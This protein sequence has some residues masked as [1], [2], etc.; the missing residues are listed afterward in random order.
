MRQN[1]FFIRQVMSFLLMVVLIVTGVHYTPKSVK[2]AP[3]DEI[4]TDTYV[5]QTET[6]ADLKTLFDDTK[7]IGTG[8][9]P[10]KP[11]KMDQN[12]NI[13]ASGESDYNLTIKA[14]INDKISLSSTGI[15]VKD[16]QNSDVSAT[17][18]DNLYLVKESGEKLKVDYLKLIQNSSDGEINYEVKA[19]DKDDNQLYGL[20]YYLVID[21]GDNDVVANINIKSI[22]VTTKMKIDGTVENNVGDGTSSNTFSYMGTGKVG[23]KIDLKELTGFEEFYY[24]NELNNLTECTQVQIVKSGNQYVLQPLDAEGNAAAQSVWIAYDHFYSFDVTLKNIVNEHS[25]DNGDVYLW[26]GTEYYITENEPATGKTPD[27]TRSVINSSLTTVKTESVNVTGRLGDSFISSELGELLIYA[28]T[29][30]KRNANMNWIN[31]KNHPSDDGGVRYYQGYCIKDYLK[32]N[33][34]TDKINYFQIYKNNEGKIMLGGVL[35]NQKKCDLR[36][37]DLYTTRGSVVKQ[38]LKWGVDK[39][40]YHIQLRVPSNVMTEKDGKLYSGRFTLI[41]G[42]G[43]VSYKGEILNSNQKFTNS[44]PDASDQQESNSLENWTSNIPAFTKIENTGNFVVNPDLFDAEKM[45]ITITYKVWGTLTAEGSTDTIEYTQEKP[46]EV[47]ETLSGKKLMQSFY[48]CPNLRGYDI[49][50]DLTTA[51]KQDI[52]KTDD[53]T[54]KVSVTKIWDDASD[55]HKLRPGS[56]TVTLERS[57]DGTTWNTFDGNT[58]TITGDSTKSIWTKELTGIQTTF[59]DSDGNVTPYQFRIK[60]NSETGA[61]EYTAAYDGLVVTNKLELENETE[62]TVNKKWLDKNGNSL[63]ENIP[64]SIDYYIYQDGKYYAKGTLSQSNSWSQTL[65]KLPVYKTATDKYTYTCCEL[66]EKGEKLSDGEIIKIDGKNYE[67]KVVDSSNGKKLISIV[68]TYRPIRKV[69][70]TKKVEN[71][72]LEKY[73]FPDSEDTNSF[74][75]TLKITNGKTF[76]DA[77]SYNTEKIK[78]E[79]V[80]RYSFSLK[81]NEST[82]L[83]VL[84]G[85]TV[86]TEEKNRTEEY[87]VCEWSSNVGGSSKSAVAVSSVTKEILD[88]STM[89]TICADQSRNKFV[90]TFVNGEIIDDTEAPKGKAFVGNSLFYDEINNNIGRI[91]NSVFTEK[92]PFTI[93]MRIKQIKEKNNY[94]TI[95]AKGD[96]QIAA[97]IENE[98]KSL[99]VYVWNGTEWIDYVFT[100]PDNWIGH[101]HHLAITFNGTN[102]VAYCDGVEMNN[103]QKRDINRIQTSNTAYGIGYE[104]EHLGERDGVNEYADFRIYNRSLSQEEI[105]AQMNAYKDNNYAIDA[106][107]ENVVMWMDYSKVTTGNAFFKTINSDTELLCENQ[108]TYYGDVEVQGFQMNTDTNGVAQYS[109][110]FRVISR[111]CE[112]LKGSDGKLHKVVN[113][114]TIYS[115]DKN[116]NADY[117]KNLRIDMS[118]GRINGEA[119]DD[120]ETFN[121]N[122]YHFQATGTERGTYSSW[123]TRNI[124]DPYYN[125]YALTFVMK[126]YSYSWLESK[127]A[128]RAYAVI[129]YDDGHKEYVYGTKIYKVS[130]YEIAENLY[131]NRKMGTLEGHQFLYTNVLNLV[132]MNKHR[133]DI[134]LAMMKALDVKSLE[135]RNYIMANQVNY[136][137]NNYVYCKNGYSYL[138]R[139]YMELTPKGLTEEEQNTLL[140]N[141][142]AA[143]N[144]SEKSLFDWIYHQ[145]SN[146]GYGGTTYQGFYKIVPYEWDDDTNIHEGEIIN[147]NL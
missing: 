133:T 51:L 80:G 58:V 72:F 88:N 65:E 131:Q 87:D 11:A 28:A 13:T 50:L 63:T 26:Q 91:M 92:K 122:I 21:N 106:T 1:K 107:N 100:L 14:P 90:G 116:V 81:N 16:A 98:N 146:Y 44:N 117:D 124:E 111:A 22:K 43:V 42:T 71:T 119:P 84:E 45:N 18:T 32:L 49:M 141:L 136:D 61:D 118:N 70:I 128:F 46:L 78:R 113:Y 41:G 7:S 97:R 74:E 120:T 135:D 114:G 86:I 23:D 110:S 55:Y 54:S 8:T 95:F 36:D 102:F 130:L 103:T 139:K 59:T 33:S 99:K 64:G 76:V 66:N 52:E 67:S 105:L 112:E 115:L 56:V 142:N 47:T 127:M 17:V 104:S 20:Y 147:R 4:I 57:G 137:I 73:K 145:T 75:F 109:P 129:E 101:W 123:T 35:P 134:C 132:T 96:H 25:E 19:Y 10:V 143:S 15:T 34:F 94:N 37:M 69:T 53:T 60:E 83:E 108:K 62:L 48:A 29:G 79:D 2:A 27:G 39:E 93:E 12:G 144:T 89:D 3:T 6:K 125:Y 140:N 138:E 5:V 38:Q 68:N 77:E 31:L 9:L 126:S 85:Y 121:S 30:E 40:V 24:G 82:S